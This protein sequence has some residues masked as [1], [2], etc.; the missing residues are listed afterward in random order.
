MKHFFHHLALALVLC[1]L[2]AP[3]ARADRRP[4]PSYAPADV[5][6]QRQ[7]ATLWEQRFTRDVSAD[8][9]P[10]IDAPDMELAQRTVRA[11]GRLEQP[12][13]LPQLQKLR[14]E[15]QAAI[16][17]GKVD[18]SKLPRRYFDYD[19]A[20]ARIESRNLH[21]REKIEFVLQRMPQHWTWEQAIEWSQKVSNPKTY[22]NPN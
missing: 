11:L 20:I 7:F 9:L 4:G 22:S 3:T 18:P 1:A 15:Q 13:V 19:T 16:E 14:D 6:L 2:F 17:A 8:L 10:F 21:G 5:A 12:T